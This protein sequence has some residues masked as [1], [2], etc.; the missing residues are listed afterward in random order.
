MLASLRKLGDSNPR[1][2]NPHGSFGIAHDFTIRAGQHSWQY[3]VESLDKHL[4]FFQQALTGKPVKCTTSIVTRDKVSKT[5][6]VKKTDAKTPEIKTP[7]AKKP[8]PKKD[9]PK[10]VEKKAETK[11]ETPATTP[12]T[13][14][15]KAA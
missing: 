9:T 4:K 14:V 10:P 7:E 5:P 3:W 11:Q 15:S 6:E 1:Y 8:E 12:Q 2:G 13:E